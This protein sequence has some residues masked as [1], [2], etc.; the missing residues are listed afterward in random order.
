MFF[1]VLLILIFQ[2]FLII[3]YKCEY[4]AILSPAKHGYYYPLLKNCRSWTAGFKEASWSGSTLFS[5][6]LVNHNRKWNLQLGHYLHRHD[7]Q[8]IYLSAKEHFYWKMGFVN[9][10][11]TSDLDIG[12]SQKFRRLSPLDSC[13]C[14]LRYLPTSVRLSADIF[15]NSL[16]PDLA[17]Q[18]YRA[19]S[20]SKLFVTLMVF[21]K[22]NFQ[23]GWFF[24]NSTDDKKHEKL[25]TNQARQNV[26]RDLDP[27]CLR[28]MVY[29]KEIFK[30]V[31]FEKKNLQVTKKHEKIPSRQS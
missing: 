18:K 3:N 23:K 1:L 12:S 14:M 5:I 10:W 7:T 26:G 17:R 31:D 27:N 13:A 21:L 25:P 20:G 6:P 8:R 29:L 9:T 30:I 4:Q 2:S 15:A 22:R 11:Y 16:D 19:G 28:L 24:C